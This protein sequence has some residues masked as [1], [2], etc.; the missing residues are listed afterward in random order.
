VQV[1]PLAGDEAEEWLEA[2]EPRTTGVVATATESGRT[3]LRFSDGVRITATRGDPYVAAILLHWR[4]TN[5][6]PYTSGESL[7]ALGYATHTI[8]VD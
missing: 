5:G 8:V 2:Q 7:A 3:R 1:E 6:V 4:R